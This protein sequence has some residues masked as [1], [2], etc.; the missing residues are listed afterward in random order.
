LWTIA[1]IVVLELVSNNIVEPLLYGSSTGLSAISL[2]ASAMFW[3]ALWGPAGLILS[4][5]LTVCLLVL[6]RNLPQLQFLDTLLGSTPVLDLPTRIYQRLIAS[7]QDEAIELADQEIEKTSVR[8]F[9]N[10]VC[11]D[12]LR[13]ASEDHVRKSTAE[14]RLRFAA[15]MDA[16][17]DEL[18]VE[19]PPERAETAQCE[20][21][22]IGGKWHV[23]AIAARILAHALQLEGVRA[24]ARPAA[25]VNRHYVEQLPLKGTETVCISYFSDDPMLPARHFTRRLRIRWPNLH[26]VLA[27]WNAPSELFEDEARARLGADAV[28]NSVDEAVQRIHRL[29]APEAAR[30]AQ[31]TEIPADDTDRSAAVQTS[32]LLDGRHRE[33]LD[34]LAKRAAD[35]FDA[36]IAVIST[37]DADREYFVGQSGDFPAAVIDETGALSPLARSEAICNYVIGSDE[38][39][40]IPDI[41]RDPRFADNDAIRRWGVRSYAGAALRSKDGVVLGAFCILDDE[42][43]DFEQSDIELLEKM[44]VE[45]GAAIRDDEP[46]ASANVASQPASATVGQLV[47]R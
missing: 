16:L 26:I 39:L 24:D 2:I 28:V 17:L 23:D 44:A 40:V 32:G 8:A 20:V 46:D 33:V 12:V 30:D 3:T 6:G 19:R 5:P 36:S 15:G 43:R 45:V 4:T 13:R 47:P 11:I 14:H 29:V 7:D 42:P 34:A 25:T 9:Y 37:I 22:C 31:Q 1:L 41:E 38:T 21:I 35:V 18:T 27:L 10:D